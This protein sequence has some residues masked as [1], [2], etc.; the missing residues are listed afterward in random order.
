MKK[1]VVLGILG[2]SAAFCCISLG[3]AAWT[4]TGQMTGEVNGNF[5]AYDATDNGGVV[6][7]LCDSTG[8]TTN[9]ESIVFG[10]P[11]STAGITD[12]WLS[13]SSMD[14]ENLDAY[15]KVTYEKSGDYPSG[16]V[17]FNVAHAFVNA[18]DNSA[19]SQTVID[20][21]TITMVSAQSSATGVSFANNVITYTANGFAVLKI[22]YAWKTIGENPYTYYNGQS[23]TP[24]LRSEA[25]NYING[26]Y[27]VVGTGNNLKFVVTISKVE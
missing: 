14:S 1:R 26:L 16:G 19:S 21:P 24:A 8:T 22:S 6:V 11:A 10:A 13:F 5:Q 12:P 2:F 18:S 27:D 15:V 7:E 23:M 9:S 20:A 3:Y 17:T 25:Y 4:I